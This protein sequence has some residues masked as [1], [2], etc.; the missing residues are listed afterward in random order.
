MTIRRHSLV[1]VFA[2]TTVAFGL[3]ACGGTDSTPS[4]P[5]EPAVSFEG[6]WGIEDEGEPHITI[7]EDGTL[8]GTTGC[9]HVTGSWT[10]E[11]D[12]IEFG[13]M[14]STQMYC[15][16]VDEWLLNAT[17]ATIPNPDGA[18]LVIVD[19]DGSELGSLT[20]Q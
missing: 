11:G 1:A 15:E 14:A 20:K 18:Q 7:A 9:N 19:S 2:A 10:A 17:S 12:T 13:P 16:G 5:Q 4:E 6:T 8:S 3:S